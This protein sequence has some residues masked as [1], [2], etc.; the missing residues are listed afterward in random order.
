V[1]EK[2]VVADPLIS[3]LLAGVVAI[4]VDLAALWVCARAVKM[5]PVPTLLLSGIVLVFA[6]LII[7][8]K[9]R[10][11]RKIDSHE[12]YCLVRW[13]IRVGDLC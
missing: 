9:L 2:N 4:L 12:R 8:S 7:G 10:Q 5:S 11:E 6:G 1:D 13:A 3:I